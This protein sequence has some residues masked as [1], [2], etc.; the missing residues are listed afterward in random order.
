VISAWL[1][2]HKTRE[3]ETIFWALYGQRELLNQ[4][5]WVYFLNAP[6]A[7]LFNLQF[8]I[9]SLVRLIGPNH[10][11]ATA[12]QFELQPGD[13]YLWFGADGVRKMGELQIKG[14]RSDTQFMQELMAPPAQEIPLP[15]EVLLV[16]WLPQ[17]QSVYFALSRRAP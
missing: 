17:T 3:T 5:G 16:H 13:Q 1:N 9:T 11:L 14:L 10:L 12:V 7:K 8:A 15:N 2:L 6:Y 4:V